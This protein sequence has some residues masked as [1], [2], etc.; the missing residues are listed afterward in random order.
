MIELELSFTG[1][2]K[3]ALSKTTFRHPL[4][5]KLGN[6][7]NA[8]RGRDEGAHPGD[9]GSFTWSRAV[10]ALAIFLLKWAA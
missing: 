5:D 1:R 7:Q 10:Q 4:L 3:P 2:C 8:V 6:E 9:Y